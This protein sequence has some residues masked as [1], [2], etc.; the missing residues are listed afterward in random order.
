MRP[1][2]VSTDSTADIPED[3]LKEVEAHL[4]EGMTLSD[5]T[6]SWTETEGIRTLRCE[7]VLEE[8]SG[9]GHVSWKTH[10]LVVDTEGMTP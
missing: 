2:I 5:H 1:F 7:A 6:V 3:Y 10:R 8:I 9:G 4:P